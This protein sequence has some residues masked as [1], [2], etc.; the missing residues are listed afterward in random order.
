MTDHRIIKKHI[1]DGHVCESVDFREGKL[2]QFLRSGIGLSA[3][4][5]S[6]SENHAMTG[7]IMMFLECEKDMSCYDKCG[8][9]ILWKDKIRYFSGG[10]CT[11]MFREI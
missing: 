11:R 6:F 8:I 5:D 3:R 2:Y 4:T 1:D 10:L 9:K 7:D